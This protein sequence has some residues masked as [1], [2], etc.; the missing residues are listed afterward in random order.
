MARKK[1]RC[2]VCQ[3][4]VRGITIWCDNCSF[5]FAVNK[6]PEVIDLLSSSSSDDEDDDAPIAPRP[7]NGKSR[8]ASPKPVAPAEDEVKPCAASTKPA[9]EAEAEAK[10][11]AASKRHAPASPI[12]N[13]P[14]TAH[15]KRPKTE[16]KTIAKPAQA[17]TT[18]SSAMPETAPAIV[19]KSVAVA[20][21]DAPSASSTPRAPVD[22]TP[23]PSAQP[24][25][26]SPAHERRHV[27]YTKPAPSTKPVKAAGTPKS[28]AIRVCKPG[29]SIVPAPLLAANPPLHMQSPRLARL[30]TPPAKAALRRDPLPKL[31]A[32]EKSSHRLHH[33]SVGERTKV[34]STEYP[35]PKSEMTTEATPTS[36]QTLKVGKRKR[37][38]QDS[39]DDAAR[40]TPS[41]IKC[42]D[43]ASEDAPAAPA[44]LPPPPSL[45][46][47]HPNLLLLMQA[48]T[49]LDSDGFP[50]GARRRGLLQARRAK[51]GFRSS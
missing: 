34:H 39:D 14:A 43:G 6:P 38:R 23:T 9:A 29:Q 50:P 12:T 31:E 37:H 17:A 2:I 11:R 32:T 41:S 45:G 24:A 36:T 40:P 16:T 19:D 33:R 4:I 30:S 13:A 51:L 22:P 26:A 15:T 27:P 28:T 49:I 3:K 47:C 1:P 48:W 7:A 5:H 44:P 8:A 18:T 42:E 35:L 20:P 25:P 21:P 10:P 46:A